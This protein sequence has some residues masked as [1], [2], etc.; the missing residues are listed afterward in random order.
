AAE[1]MTARIHYYY[2]LSSSPWW[3]HSVRCLL[4]YSTFISNH[5]CLVYLC[6]YPTS[7]HS[8][9]RLY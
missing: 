8:S 4:L 9:V 1:L 5:T 7:V 3:L 2:M 6:P